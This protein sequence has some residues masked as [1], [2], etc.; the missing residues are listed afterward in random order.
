M[1]NTTF[2]KVGGAGGGVMTPSSKG[3]TLKAVKEAG[4]SLQFFHHDKR[5]MLWNRAPEVVAEA[6][7]LFLDVNSYHHKRAVKNCAA[8]S[9]SPAMMREALKNLFSRFTRDDMMRMRERHLRG[10]I[11]LPSKLPR[12][13]FHVFA[14]NLFLSSL[15]SLIHASL[16]GACSLGRCSSS[17]PVFPQLW[18]DAV[19]DVDAEFAKSLV[20]GWWPREYEDVTRAAGEHADVT[21]AFG[22]DET[23][24][25]LKGLAGSASRFIGHGFKVSFA[26]LRE[27][28]LA[29]DIE[30]H[31]RALAYDFSIYDQAGC[32][33][34]RAAFFQTES[35]EFADEFA[36]LLAEEM[37]AIA[38]RLPPH[39]LSLEESAALARARDEALIEAAAG[40]ETIIASRGGDPFL[41]T[42]RSAA[43]F[44]L[45]CTNRFCDL[46]TFSAHIGLSGILAS[47]AGRIS[48]MGI[49]GE[50]PETST[51]AGKAP[52]YRVCPLG[53]MQRPPLDWL[54]DGFPPLTNLA[55]TTRNG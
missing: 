47:F 13:V 42:V 15:E 45:G 19:A 30:K 7:K 34:P 8:A 5:E 26:V 48:T 43:G 3:P 51:H 11:D 29:H 52:A 6:A 2:I 22:D 9:M 14:G 18:V 28:D 23:I 50:F 46:R 41:V 16:C 53:R 31:A 37:R 38:R 24:G 32:L 55:L 39:D 44:R 49:P 40:G 54:H 1:M 4:A 10:Q 36:G 20:V 21:V 33:S 17:D 27:D 25:R 35:G 12:I